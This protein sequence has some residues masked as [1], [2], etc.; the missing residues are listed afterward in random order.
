MC[1]FCFEQRSGSFRVRFRVLSCKVVNFQFQKFHFLSHWMLQTRKKDRIQLPEM[2][3]FYFFTL[4]LNWT[5]SFSSGFQR[6]QI[7][8][9]W[10]HLSVEEG[11]QISFRLCVWPLPFWLSFTKRGAHELQNAFTASR[12]RT[13]R[14]NSHGNL[15][16][17]TETER[18]T[19]R[20]I[21]SRA[22]IGSFVL[23]LSSH[24][25]QAGSEEQNPPK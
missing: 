20:S 10:L 9:L 16:S 4:L 13:Q 23:V 14:V 22:P 15:S 3:A 5:E 17:R 18:Y 8:N 2:L 11:T 7:E 12:L 24:C 1:D 21:P 6:E 19:G 25:P